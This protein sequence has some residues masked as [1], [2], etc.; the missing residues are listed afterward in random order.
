MHLRP[1]LSSPFNPKI[2]NVGRRRSSFSTLRFRVTGYRTY[3]AIP[4]GYNA[5]GFLPQVTSSI[6]SNA[7]NTGATPIHR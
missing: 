2:N 3:P 4:G 7:G 5:A 1:F 6:Q